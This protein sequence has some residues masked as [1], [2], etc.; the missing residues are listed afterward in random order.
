MS[1]AYIV[2]IFIIAIVGLVFVIG[3]ILS[4]A[5]QITVEEQQKFVETFSTGIITAKDTSM[6]LA[7]K[8]AESITYEAKMHLEI[9]EPDRKITEQD[10][11]NLPFVVIAF[12]DDETFSIGK[13][14][15]NI[16]V[17]DFP[18]DTKADLEF[19]FPLGIEPEKVKTVHITFWKKSSCVEKNVVK[20]ESLLELVDACPEEY[21]YASFFQVSGVLDNS[22][23]SCEEAVAEECIKKDQCLWRDDECILNPLYSKDV[24]EITEIKAE[25]RGSFCEVEFNIINTGIAAWTEDDK[26]KVVISCPTGERNLIIPPSASEYLQINPGAPWPVKASHDGGNLCYSSKEF[27]DEEFVVRLYKNCVVDREDLDNPCPGAEI[28]AERPFTC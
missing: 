14:G 6:S 21:L 23:C 19:S 10:D 17:I 4:P 13:I 24:R 22:E 2:L 11:E 18:T 1:V 28:I 9:N 20:Q 5:A 8:K 7:C 12:L 27:P 26:V 3:V 25:E 16:G 15:D